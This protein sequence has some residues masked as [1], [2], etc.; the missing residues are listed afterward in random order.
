[1]ATNLKDKDETIKLEAKK[2]K[3]IAKAT[4]ELNA[5]NNVVTSTVGRKLSKNKRKNLEKQVVQK[6]SGAI[7]NKRIKSEKDRNKLR[8]SLPRV[9]D[10][11]RRW[12]GWRDS[13]GVKSEVVT[14]S[15]ADLEKNKENS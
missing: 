14:Y 3:K 5:I 1:M 13:D 15:L 9:R 2:K 12:K 4:Q 8:T 11:G 6:N 10:E 7:L